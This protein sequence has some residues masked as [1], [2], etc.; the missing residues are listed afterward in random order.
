MCHVSLTPGPVRSVVASL[1]V[2]VGVDISGPGGSDRPGIPP[3]QQRTSQAAGLTP[4][5][6]N[7]ILATVTW[8]RSD[9]LRESFELWIRCFLTGM[10]ALTF[11]S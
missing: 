11:F 9:Q 5:M 4:G 2:G 3:S 1:S 6:T 7:T 8:L 10:L